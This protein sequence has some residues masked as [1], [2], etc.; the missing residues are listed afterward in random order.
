[1][2][3]LGPE[4]PRFHREE[5]EAAARLGFAPVVG[6][7]ELSRELVAGAAAAGAPA[8]WFATAAEAAPWARAQLAAGDVVLVKGSRGVRLEK[9]VAALAEEA[10]GRALM[11]YHLL[12]PLADRW[13][14]FNVFRYITFRSA[15][16]VLTAVLLSLLLGPAFVRALRRL[17]VGQNIRELGPEGAP[18]EGGDAD[19]GRAAHP[20]LLRRADAA[21]GAARQPLRL[22]RAARHR[23]A[24]APSASSTTIARSSA[25]RT[26]A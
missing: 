13:A 9:V 17:S 21:V 20:L 11:L 18:G 3:E 1:M 8:Q 25:A 12:F 15:G 26:S 10:G 22:D 7:G 16:A 2:L 5:G 23:S 4:A 24:S 6:V 19:D 14:V